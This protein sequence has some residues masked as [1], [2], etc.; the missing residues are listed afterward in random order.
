MASENTTTA[1]V[2]VSD[3]MIPDF[4][5][6]VGGKQISKDR[7]LASLRAVFMI[8]TSVCTMLGFSVNLDGIYQTILVVL[9]AAS[10]LWGYW[11]NN[12]W[13]K[14]AVTAQKIQDELKSSVE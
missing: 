14:S 7:V 8:A 13:T 10:M 12:N 1:K 6:E 5:I 3:D 4:E 11:K 9:M 2:A